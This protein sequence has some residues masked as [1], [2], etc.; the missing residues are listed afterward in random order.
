MNI[1]ISPKLL[2][3]KVDIISSK[4]DI[5]RLLIAAALADKPTDIIFSNFSKDISDTISALNSLGAKCERTSQGARVYPLSEKEKMIKKSGNTYVHCGESGSTARFLL[6]LAALLCESAEITGEGSLLSRPF[7]PL[8]DALRSGGCNVVGDTLPILVSGGIRALEYSIAGDISSQYITGLLFALSLLPENSKIVLNSTLQSAGYID[9][10]LDT[11]LRFGVKVEK[12][13]YG[14][15]LKGG[16]KYISPDKISA[17]GDWSN[18]AFWLTAGALCKSVTVGGLCPMSFQKDKQI[19]AILKKMGAKVSSQANALTIE[20]GSLSKT[21][22]DA[23]DIPDIVP[24]IAVAAATAKG[25]TIIKNAGRLKIKESDRLSTVTNMLLSLG[26]VCEK[27]DDSLII[28]GIPRL[29]GGTVDGAGDH[30]I[31][32]S[33]AIA[34]CVCANDVLILGAEAADKSYPEFFSDFVKLGGKIN[35]V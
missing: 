17:E 29:S 20:R 1:K 2:S 32:M 16:Q 3:G 33:A 12:K 10:T 5:H 15:Y 7:G 31:V 11:M 14:F 26:A 30:R 23:A 24:I 25:R 4:S 18:A 35:V 8:C 13:D 28:D 34:S 6:P 9:M 19:T 21:T 27:T 22:I